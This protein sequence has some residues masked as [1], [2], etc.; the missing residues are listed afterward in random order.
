MQSGT[1]HRKRKA[2]VGLVVG[3]VMALTTATAA[4]ASNTGWKTG[5]QTNPNGNATFA[6]SYMWYSKND[7][8]GGFR[9]KGTLKDNNKKNGRANKVEISVA[10]YKAKE[11]KA[12][13]DKDL[14]VP[15]LVHYDYAMLITPDGYIKTCETISLY[16]DNCSAKKKFTN[17]YYK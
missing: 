13:K 9:V 16:P 7:N 12:T 6:Y 17:P 2:L 4:Y 14:T 5:S 11:Y 10:G 15:D 8:H 1:T 3:A